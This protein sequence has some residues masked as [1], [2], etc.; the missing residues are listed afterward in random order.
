MRRRC[1]LFRHRKRVLAL[2]LTQRD[3]PFGSLAK[4]KLE[5]KDK[6]KIESIPHRSALRRVIVGAYALLSK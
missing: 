4:V 1:R 3:L 6:G 5:K 2:E